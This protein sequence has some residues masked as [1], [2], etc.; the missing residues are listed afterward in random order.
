MIQVKKI[1]NQIDTKSAIDIREEVFV[2][3]QKVPKE[4][5]YDNY[6]QE[7]YHFLA[8]Y[9]NTPC[10]TARWRFTEKG[11][12]LERFAVLKEFRD[13]KVGK[14]ILENVLHDIKN[15]PESQNKALYLHAQIQVVEFYEK[16][17]FQ[18][19]GEPFQECDIWHYKM[20]KLED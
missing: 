16:F 4:D 10:G 17:G 11:V 12:K 9:E 19:L 13:K 5:E 6:E 14:A 18:K 7:S 1:D 8:Y 15:H 2:K 3:E 20:Q